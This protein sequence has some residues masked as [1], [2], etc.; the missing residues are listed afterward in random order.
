[1]RPLA[2]AEGGDAPG[3]LEEGFPSV[4]AVIE[5]VFV[6]CEDAVRQPVF[7]HELPD[8][9]LRI[10]FWAFGWQRDDSDVGRDF[11]RVCEMPAGLIEEQGCVSAGRDAFGDLGQVQVHGLR[12]AARED[13]AGACA[14]LWAD[15]AEDIG[16]GRALIFR[17][18][19]T[20]TAFCPA[21]GDL[22]LLSDA[23]FVAEPDFYIASFDALLLRD[24]LQARG[25]VFL[26]SSM[27]PSA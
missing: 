14:L 16:R 17:R 26:N 18:R 11:Q 2:H 10:E 22:V 20:R 19:R 7:S 13:E 1:M 3:S 27:A 21:A 24:L 8:I 5:D 6:G 15:R 12:V 4:A 25:E 9:L 23:R